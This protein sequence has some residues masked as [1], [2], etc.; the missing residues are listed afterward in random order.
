MILLP[1]IIKSLQYEKEFM[2]LSSS[3]VSHAKNA[4]SEV[5]EEQRSAAIQKET[6]EIILNARKKAIEITENAKAEAAAIVKTLEDSTRNL[7]AQM[8]IQSRQEGHE[9][10]LS[11]GKS[12][13][14]AL[15]YQEGYEE[16]L[17][18]AENEY[19]YMSESFEEMTRDFIR[20]K[21]SVIE[22]FSDGL[23]ASV[24]T[25]AKAVIKREIEINPEFLMQ[26]AYDAVA[27]C[28]KDAWIKIYISEK[29]M[30]TV[31][32]NRPDFL[33]NLKGDVKLIASADMSDTD[34]IC[35]TPAKIIDA[36]IDTQ[37]E[38]VTLNITGDR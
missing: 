34:C 15:G 28:S 37:F 8:K 25:V 12:E 29:M 30:Q 16:G 23:E 26:L 22:S 9:T 4:L 24:L 10:G 3:F 31:S 11:E 14:F 1:N 33:E 17:A 18:R 36:G 21:K 13:G 38:N 32:L 7:C 19:R 27:D 5:S 20:E 35:E 2:H 6:E